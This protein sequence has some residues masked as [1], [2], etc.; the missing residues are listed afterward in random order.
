[1]QVLEKIIPAMKVENGFGEIELLFS[2]PSLTLKLLYASFDSNPIIGG[3]QVKFPSRAVAAFQVTE[4]AVQS[5]ASE[6][7]SKPWPI[8]EG[9]QTYTYPLLKVNNSAWIE[10]LSEAQKTLSPGHLS[11][12]R[13][14]SLNNIIDVLSGS[15]PSITCL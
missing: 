6:S 12:Y 1:M 13:F 7:T 11:H 10:S 8:L 4:E 3:I 14:L 5:V 2:T 15:P 9:P